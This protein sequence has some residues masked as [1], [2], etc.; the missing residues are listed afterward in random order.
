MKLNDEIHMLA[1]ERDWCRIVQV[2][3]VSVLFYEGFDTDDDLHKLHAMVAT[4][5]AMMDSVVSSKKA[6]PQCAFNTFATKKCA[7]EAIKLAHDLGF[8][9]VVSPPKDDDPC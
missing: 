3:G 7:A 1:P 2:D 8:T 6:F 4:E 5:G 9:P